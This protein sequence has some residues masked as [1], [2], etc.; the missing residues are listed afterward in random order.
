MLSTITPVTEQGRGRHYAATVP[1]YLL[2]ALAGGATLGGVAALASIPVRAADIPEMTVLAIIGLFAVVSIFSDLGVG[3]FQL[4]RHKRQVDRLWLDH[5]RSWV[6]GTGFGW[7]IGVGLATYIVTTAVYL[8]VLIGVLTSSPL[9][10]LT[11]GLLFGGVRGLAI[12]LGARATTLDKLH[13]LHR[14]LTRFEPASR[15]FMFT[16]QAIVASL[17][18]GEAWGTAGGVVTVA[19]VS[20]VGLYIIRSRKTRP[21]VADRTPTPV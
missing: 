21:V 1:W 11:I 18:I 4:P 9:Q 6:Y 3:G 14:G 5:Y 8:T 17:A 19:L 16:I 2:G 15:A 13:G 10:A 20:V 7:Q 12:F